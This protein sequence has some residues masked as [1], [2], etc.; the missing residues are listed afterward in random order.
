MLLGGLLQCGRVAEDAESDEMGNGVLVTSRLQ[1]GRVAE[2]AESALGTS[3][4]VIVAALL[5]CGRVAEDAESNPFQVRRTTGTSP[6]IAS[7][8]LS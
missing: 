1:C 4:E 3:A 8:L 5:Q 6:P 7:D 2:D